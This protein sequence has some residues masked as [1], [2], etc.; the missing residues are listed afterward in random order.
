MVTAEKARKRWDPLRNKLQAK[1]MVMMEEVS[2]LEK[3]MFEPAT[4]ESGQ[5]RRRSSPAQHAQV[6][7]T[8]KARKRWDPLRN[9]LQAKLMVMMEEVSKLE[10]LMFE[11]ATMEFGQKRNLISYMTTWLV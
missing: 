9:K 2:K 10:E 1:L 7:T 5:E 11:S 3:L 8:E 6:V 4:M